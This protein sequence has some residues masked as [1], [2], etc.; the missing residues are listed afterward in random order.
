LQSRIERGFEPGVLF[1]GHQSKGIGG[2]FWFVIYEILG[3]KI[4][5]EQMQRDGPAWSIHGQYSQASQPSLP[6]PHR[7]AAPTGGATSASAAGV[8]LVG[9]GSGSLGFFDMTEDIYD[10]A[11]WIYGKEAANTPRLGRQ[12]I[13]YLDALR[14]SLGM[15]RIN[16]G[17]L[18]GDRWRLRWRLCLHDG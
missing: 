14:H 13:N 3:E 5:P 9:I 7:P 12:R 6:E 10:D 15:H 2:P 16:V 18:D 1:F 17:Y 4:E 11:V 8:S